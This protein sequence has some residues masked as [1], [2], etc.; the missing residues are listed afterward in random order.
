MVTKDDSLAQGKLTVFYDG[1]CPLCRSE[2]GFYKG[3]EGA[4]AI[5]FVDVSAI[6]APEVAPGLSREAALRRF[7]VMNAD[8]A[9]SS[10][11]R[12]FA[13]LWAA[14]P[15]FRAIGR[16]FRW[17]PLAGALE[18]AYRLFLPLRPALQFL[19]RWLT[20]RPDARPR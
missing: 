5:D 9:I 1:G 15:R 6:A 16:M 7:H 10:G 2:I 18:L 14:L 11:G 13:D 20:S 4:A 19:A 8:G 12:A 17:P 3:C